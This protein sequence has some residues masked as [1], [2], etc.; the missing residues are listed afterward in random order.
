MLQNIVDLDFDFTSAGYFDAKSKEDISQ[1][2]ALESAGMPVVELIAICTDASMECLRKLN[3]NISA[4][5]K[6]ALKQEHFKN[7][8]KITKGRNVT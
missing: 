8:L 1:F 6:P 7:A 5:T 3:F 2:V 4:L